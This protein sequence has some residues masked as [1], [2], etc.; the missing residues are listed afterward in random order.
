MRLIML[1]MLLFSSLAL[2]EPENP[3]CRAS[4][5][6]VTCDRPGFDALVDRMIET[7]AEVERKKIKLVT[8]NHENI[9]LRMA[10][11]GCL[12]DVR[13]KKTYPVIPLIF[14]IVGGGL[15]GAAAMASG[16]TGRLPV[17]VVGFTFIGASVIILS[18]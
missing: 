11:S 6:F 3:P 8:A 4:G 17:A 14:G 18:G 13:G 15:I 1:G 5:K 2:A 9:D 10:L 12:S 7:E 16:T